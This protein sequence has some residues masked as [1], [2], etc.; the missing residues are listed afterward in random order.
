MVPLTDRL[1]LNKPFVPLA[2]RHLAVTNKH[3]K[4]QIK[5]PNTGHFYGVL[6]TMLKIQSTRPAAKPTIIGSHEKTTNQI[7]SFL[8]EN[9]RSRIRRLTNRGGHLF[10]N[11]GQVEFAGIDHDRVVR[12]GQRRI[13][14]GDIA[15]VAFVDLGERLFVG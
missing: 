7:A 4:Q 15:F 9:L 2:G 3:M 6:P 14:A 8:N 5:L 12:D 13:F 10:E 1:T 11:F